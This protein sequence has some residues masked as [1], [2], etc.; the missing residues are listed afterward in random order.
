MESLFPETTKWNKY[1][2]SL[3]KSLLSTKQSISEM[4]AL[5]FEGKYLLTKVGEP[6]SEKGIFS[7]YLETFLICRELC[8]DYWLPTA[9]TV[10][11]TSMKMPFVSYRASPKTQQLVHCTTEAGVK[12]ITWVLQKTKPWNICICSFLNWWWHDFWAS[13]VGNYYLK[14]AL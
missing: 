10:H 14:S 9:L 12:S 2:N 13:L 6:A 7:V 8:L 3:Q 5:F 4:S 11:R 1:E